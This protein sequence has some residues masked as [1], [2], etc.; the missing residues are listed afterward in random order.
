MKLSIQLIWV[1]SLF[2]IT[3]VNAQ[4]TFN[5]CNTL[6]E[7]QDYT[8]NFLNTDGTGRNMFETNPITGDQ[9]CGGIGICEMQI[10]WNDG[11]N[12]WEIYADDGN[13][14]FANIY[15]LYYNTEAS[16]PNPPSLNLGAWVENTSVTAGLCVDGITTLSGDVQDSTL[17]VFDDELLSLVEIYPNPVEDKINIK[18]NGTILDSF[19]I[20]DINGRTVAKGLITN[21]PID[22]AKLS[23]GVYF[24]RLQ[25]ENHHIVKKVILK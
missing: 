20:S 18:S 19:I 2:V 15:V 9:D 5:A 13:G 21:Q 11:S 22:I 14:N 7:N 24:V 17:G 6:I 12:R 4:I 10:A 8:F 1:F 25:N 3:S 16:I 23:P